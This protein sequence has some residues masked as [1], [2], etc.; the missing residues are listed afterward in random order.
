MY[1]HIYTI[2][3]LYAHTVSLSVA[4]DAQ[5]FGD[6]ITAIL[7]STHTAKMPVSELTRKYNKIFGNSASKKS[8]PPGELVEK[9]KNVPGISVSDRKGKEPTREEEREREGGREGGRGGEQGRE[10]EEGGR[11]GGRKGREGGRE[12]EGREG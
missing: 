1:I 8:L 7:L 2:H 9:L 10:G 6:E 3:Y 11:E 5:L 12:G 4:A